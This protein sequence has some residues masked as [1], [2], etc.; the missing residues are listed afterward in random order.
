MIRRCS[1][2]ALDDISVGE[3][4]KEGMDILRLSSSLFSL[5]CEPLTPLYQPNTHP[6]AQ[7]ECCHSLVVVAIVA[8]VLS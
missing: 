1:F 4:R 2:D 8:V 5:L 6:L 3:E 7:G